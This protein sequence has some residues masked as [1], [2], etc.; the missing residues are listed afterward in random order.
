M[1]FLTSILLGLCMGSGVAISMQYGK[2]AQDSMRRSVFYVLSADP[3]DWR[4]RHLGF[5]SNR[6]GTCGSDRLCSYAMAHSLVLCDIFFQTAAFLPDLLCSFFSNIAVMPRFIAG[7][8]HIFFIL[9]I[10]QDK[11][12]FPGMFCQPCVDF[13]IGGFCLVRIDID[14][15]PKLVLACTG[16][17]DPF[18]CHLFSP[19]DC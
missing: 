19:E 4:N 15:N 2:R 3:T 8:G 10:A 16:R 17:S 6:M 18:R 13:I 11:A 14:S 5:R 7:P 1:V 9:G 12:V